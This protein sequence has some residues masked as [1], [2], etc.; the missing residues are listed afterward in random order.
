M[1]REAV[2]KSRPEITHGRT[3]SFN[4]FVITHPEEWVALWPIYSLADVFEFE[5]AEC[6]R[7]WKVLESHV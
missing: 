2:K 5:R 6:H 3:S 4:D 7:Q 1:L